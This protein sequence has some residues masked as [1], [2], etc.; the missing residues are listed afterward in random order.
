MPSS[1]WFDGAGRVVEGKGI[2]GGG[3]TSASKLLTGGGEYHLNLDCKSAGSVGVSPSLS[4]SS[5][6][7]TRAESEVMLGE[8]VNADKNAKETA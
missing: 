4:E 1:N 8:M 3:D 2:V 6:S 7:E 5:S